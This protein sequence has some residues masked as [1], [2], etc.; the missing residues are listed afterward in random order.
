MEKNELVQQTI[1]EN[2]STFEGWIDRN[3]NRIERLAIQ[4]GCTREQARNVTEEVFR[5]CYLDLLDQREEEWNPITLFHKVVEKLDGMAMEESLD[6]SFLPFEEDRH[7]HE[8]IIHLPRD[9]KFSLILAMFHEMDDSDIA[10]LLEISVEAV[11]D[12]IDQAFLQLAKESDRPQMTKQLEFLK[13]SY[14]RLRPTFRKERIFVAEELENEKIIKKKTPKKRM[15]LWP[16]GL[17]IL[18]ALIVSSVLTSEDYQKKAAE[19]YLERFKTLFED[20]MSTRY[21]KLGLPQSTEEDAQNTYLDFYG[22]EAQMEFQNLTRRLEKELQDTGTINRKNAKEQYAAISET[23]AFPSEMLEKLIKKPLTND[24]EQSERF[25][26]EYMERYYEFQNAYQMLLSEYPTVI[27]QAMANGEMDPEQ[28]ILPEKI[29]KAV[30]GMR[31]QN[32]YPTVVPQWHTIVPIFQKNEIS[33][34]MRASLHKDLGGYVTLLESTPFVDYPD[35]AYSYNESI[36]YLLDMEKSL[37]ASWEGENFYYMLE[38]SYQELLYT[39]I[40]GYEPDLI[41]GQ[42]G[43]VKEEVRA[44][45]RTIASN[46]GTSPSAIILQKIIGEMEANDWA[47]SESQ[48]RV[49]EYHIS[50]AVLLAKEGRLQNFKL[51]GIISTGHDSDIVSLPD[52]QF[53][54]LVEDTYE[55]F[56]VEYDRKVLRDVHPIVIF[57]MFI[58]ANNHEDI[59]TMEQLFGT[60]YGSLTFEEYINGWEQVHIDL[61]QVDHVQFSKSDD[62]TGT[63]WVETDRST[64]AGAMMIKNLDHIWLVQHFHYEAPIFE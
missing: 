1:P 16:V 43:T 50:H 48:R 38:H 45:W 56:S 21:A 41:Y 25:I 57:L 26:K 5:S 9:L 7:L 6:T 12:A 4:Y 18:L 42:D 14:G 17:L 27:E 44:A 3:A 11:K 62:N 36:E 34:Q 28:S 35:L 30:K 13:L 46:G 54:R 31:T 47:E 19:K 32:I 51:S 29:Q 22:R 63:I 15:L 40:G 39:L 60:L 52:S 2:V 59:E 10:A 64:S 8:K 61:S 49:T 23:L 55:R 20:E 53:E 37:L 58:M 33:A 24:R